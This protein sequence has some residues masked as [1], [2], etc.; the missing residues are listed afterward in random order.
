MPPDDP[1]PLLELDALGAAGLLTVTVFVLTTGAGADVFAFTAADFVAGTGAPE[2]EIAAFC[3]A[4]SPAPGA[5]NPGPELA[6]GF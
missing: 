2:P 1:P 4:V 3:A 6:A 5:D